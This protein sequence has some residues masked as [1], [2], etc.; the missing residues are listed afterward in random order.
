MSTQI[1]I[2]NVNEFNGIPDAVIGAIKLI[3]KDIHFDFT[4]SKNILLKPNLL[5]TKKEACTQPGFIEG[6]LSYL[7][8][9]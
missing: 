3:E 5:T 7:K 4:K 6:V 9:H 2:V 8:N 1:S